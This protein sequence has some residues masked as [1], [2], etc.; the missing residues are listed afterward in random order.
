MVNNRRIL[1]VLA[2]L[3]VVG[4][5]AFRQDV[6]ADTVDSSYHTRTVTF[7][8]GYRAVIAMKT[9]RMNG[10]SALCV[11][12]GHDARDDG[13]FADTLIERW[14][15]LRTIAL[16]GDT[17]VRDLSFMPIYP[18]ELML[19]KT[20]TCVELGDTVAQSAKDSRFAM[21][22]PRAVRGAF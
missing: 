6:G 12:G 9:K 15:K 21:T 10:R 19:G 5:S 8:S 17:L 7:T 1:I 13:V 2:S 22:G 16:D 20:A 4:C 11:A 14:M 18:S 3:V